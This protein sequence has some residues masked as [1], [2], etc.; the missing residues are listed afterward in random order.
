MGWRHG[1]GVAA[2]PIVLGLAC[3][4]SL[5]LAL[6][7]CVYGP[8]DFGPPDGGSARD[9]DAPSFGGVR[10]SPRPAPQAL[11]PPGCTLDRVGIAIGEPEPGEQGRLLAVRTLT[12]RPGGSSGSEAQPLTLWDLDLDNGARIEALGV[13]LSLPATRLDTRRLVKKLEALLGDAGLSGRCRV[14][15]ENFAGDAGVETV[16]TALEGLAR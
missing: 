12:V 6:S 11:L 13:G 15:A 5:S 3:A 10:T 4:L 1:R 16:R 2:G 8:D 7:G 9:T 14:V